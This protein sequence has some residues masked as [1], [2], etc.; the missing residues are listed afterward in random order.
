VRMTSGCWSRFFFYLVVG[1]SCIAFQY[2]VT[3]TE[4]EGGFRDDSEVDIAGI[5]QRSADGAQTE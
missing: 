5:S 4:S 1:Q 2:T 3:W